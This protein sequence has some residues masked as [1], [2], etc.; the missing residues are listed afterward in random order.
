M[1]AYKIDVLA[2]I[3]SPR[4]LSYYIFIITKTLPT[5]SNQAGAQDD[6]EENITWD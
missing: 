5:A 1:K 4:Q 3:A 6:I 2:E